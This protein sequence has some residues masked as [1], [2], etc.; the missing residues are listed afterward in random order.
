MLD[1]AAHPEIDLDRQIIDQRRKI[2]I[3]D[4]ERFGG[5]HRHLVDLPDVDLS[6]LQ[7]GQEEI[8]LPPRAVRADEHFDRTFDRDAADPAHGAARPLELDRGA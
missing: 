7:F 5:G 6:G 1:K 3:G 8:A 2:G 4:A